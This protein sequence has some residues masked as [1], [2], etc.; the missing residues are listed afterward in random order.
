MWAFVALFGAMAAVFFVTG[1]W[2][3]GLA[4]VST[5]VWCGVAANAMRHAER[6]RDARRMMTE[7]AGIPDHTIVL[8]ETPDGEY[9]VGKYLKIAP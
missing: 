1:A 4:W 3:E 6:Q 2:V 8:I 9:H 7:L 5:T